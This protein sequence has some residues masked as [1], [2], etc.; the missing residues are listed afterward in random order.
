MAT[1]R[2]GRNGSHVCRASR[3]VGSGDCLV[4]CFR[5]LAVLRSFESS[6]VLFLFAGS[7]FGAFSCASSVL[8]FLR[9]PALRRFE[10]SRFV[11]LV[12]VRESPRVLEEWL[13]PLC[14]PL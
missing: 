4:R 1:H 2:L 9:Q 10:F 14:I 8:W 7:M 5:A 12:V 13:G 3:L 11:S 6:R